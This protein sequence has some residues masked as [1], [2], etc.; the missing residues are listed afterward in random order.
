VTS[1]SRSQ[2]RPRGRS[3]VAGLVGT[4]TPARVVDAALLAIRLVLAFLFIYHGARRLFGWFGGPGLDASADFF[5]DTA[6]LRPGEL[7]ALLGGVIEFGGGIALALG[8]MTR[9]AGAAVFGDMLMAI[10][11]VTHANG[12]NAT[13]GKA[14]YELNLA[15][16]FLAL[17]P[18]IFGAGRYSLDAQLEQRLGRHVEPPVASALEPG[19]A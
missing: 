10:I 11:T 9:L 14:G 5:A 12:L 7:W 17:T 19:T 15:L 16:A 6:G 4:R 8:L 1:T 18:A 13:G 3:V 2:T